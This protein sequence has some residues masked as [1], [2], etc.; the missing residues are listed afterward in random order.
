MNKVRTTV[1]RNPKRTKACN[2]GRAGWYPYYAG[3]SAE[4]VEDSIVFAEG[5]GSVANILDPWNGSGT[6]TQIAHQRNLHSVGFDL[7]PAMV[8]VAKAK[9]LSSNVAAS[10]PSLIEEICSKAPD[11]EDVAADEPLSA[12]LTPAGAA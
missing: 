9:I 10:V 5:R 6:T 11:E 12:W 7:N 3:Y 2:L 1:L 8:I 4:F